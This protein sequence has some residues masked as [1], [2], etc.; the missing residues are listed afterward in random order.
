[1]GILRVALKLQQSILVRRH[2]RWNLAKARDVTGK[3]KKVGPLF[4]ICWARLP[5]EDGR[6]TL[7]LQ[8]PEASV[9]AP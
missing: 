2:G 1:V 4:G 7:L 3:E 5:V 9:T 6:Q 8:A